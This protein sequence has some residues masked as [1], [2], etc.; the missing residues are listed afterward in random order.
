MLVLFIVL[1]MVVRF[2]PIMVSLHI[3]RDTRDLP[4][5]DRVS[6]AFYCTTALPLIVAVTNVAVSAGAMLQ[7][8]ASVMVAAGAVSVFLMPLLA[9]VCQSIG[10][11]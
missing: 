11:D 3:S 4:W 5:P 10:K 7:S 6:V 2:V 9:S 8:T 1:L